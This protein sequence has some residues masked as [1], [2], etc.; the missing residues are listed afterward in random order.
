M[1]LLQRFVDAQDSEYRI[2]YAE[3][4]K[5]K[6]ISHWIWFIFPQLYGLGVSEM[7]KRY[8]L[9]I[10][11][12]VLFLDHPILSLRLRNILKILLEHKNKDIVRIMGELDALKLQASMTLFNE[13]SPDDIFG[14]VLDVFYGGQ[15]HQKTL[16]L[17]YHV[18][19]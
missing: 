10:D 12:A 19:E 5:G 7:S 6:K 14:E 16:N 18:Q 4:K 13:F 1:D 8:G 3:M 2:A 15:K 11:E 17:I 9:T